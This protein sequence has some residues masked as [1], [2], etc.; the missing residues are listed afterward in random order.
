MAEADQ[1]QRLPTSDEAATRLEQS[2]RP[3]MLAPS[4]QTVTKD[5]SMQTVTKEW[6]VLKEG[7]TT[8]ERL[9]KSRN[10]NHSGS[11]AG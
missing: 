3:P 10:D 9:A 2:H 11:V 1:T 8:T 7:Q 4:M 6:W 5:P